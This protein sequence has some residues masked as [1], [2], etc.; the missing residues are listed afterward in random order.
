MFDF[1]S[2]RHKNIFQYEIAI[3]TIDIQLIEEDSPLHYHNGDMFFI[4]L[5]RNKKNYQSKITILQQKQLQWQDLLTFNASL[6]QEEVT[7]TTFSHKKKYKEK[8]FKITLI[9]KL[10]GKSKNKTIASTQ[11]DLSKYATDHN[12]VTETEFIELKD[13]NDIIYMLKLTIRCQPMNY[14]ANTNFKENNTI[15]KDAMNQYRHYNQPNSK[16]E[17]SS[18]VKVRRS[19]NKQRNT[20]QKRINLKRKKRLFQDEDTSGEDTTTTN[21]ENHKQQKKKKKRKQV[22]F[23]SPSANSSRKSKR[24]PRS[25]RGFS[26][27]HIDINSFTN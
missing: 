15:W 6:F 8:Q 25:L 5:K 4:T 17:E 22:Y 10:A 9:Q 11:L 14:H 24:T 20:I 1:L 7:N 26:R 16:I 19:I 21:N 23:Q 12:I 13:I 2:K 3:R 27:F 18:L